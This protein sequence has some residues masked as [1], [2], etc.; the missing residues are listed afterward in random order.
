MSRR[1]ESIGKSKVMTRLTSINNTVNG[2]VYDELKRGIM[3]LR[4]EPGTVMSTQ[5]MATKLGVSRTPVREAFL[6]LQSEGLVETVPQRLTVVSRIDLARVEQE[7]FL[8]KSLESAAIPLLLQ[9][10]TPEALAAL[11]DSVARQRQALAQG[12][13]AGFIQ[14]DNQFHATIFMAAGQELSWSTIISNN[15]H[16]NRIRALITRDLSVIEGN[17]R[18]HGRM[19]ELIRQGEEEA[20]SR[21]FRSHVSK[22]HLEKTE[23]VLRYPDYFSHGDDAQPGVRTGVF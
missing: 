11:E 23:L 3:T 2:A 20:L 21:E 14:Y 18:Q 9:R 4:L 8:R 5:E 1:A 7:H 13:C 15:G 22:L 6:R 12:D 10:C 19:V 16:Y 17:I